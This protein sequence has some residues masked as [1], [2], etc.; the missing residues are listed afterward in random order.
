MKFFILFEAVSC[1]AYSEA[2][3]RMMPTVVETW[4]RKTTGAEVDADDREHAVRLGRQV[5]NV[6]ELLDEVA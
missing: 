4:I 6:R 3:L 5:R 2:D 1:H